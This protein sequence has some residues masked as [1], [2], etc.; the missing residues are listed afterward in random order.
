MQTH[1]EGDQREVSSRACAVSRE[2]HAGFSKVGKDG[3]GWHLHLLRLCDTLCCGQAGSSFLE[4]VESYMVE[5]TMFCWNNSQSDRGAGRMVLWPFSS[6][7]D[8]VM[9]C[10]EA[11]DGQVIT[12]PI[13]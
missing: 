11:K 9:T 2:G 12:M 8:A 13:P 4:F 1:C 3:S 10:L 7:H 6:A 5:D